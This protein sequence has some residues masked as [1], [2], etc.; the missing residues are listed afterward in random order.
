MTGYAAFGPVERERGPVLVDGPA[1]GSHVVAD[2]AVVIDEP[3]P[4]SVLGARV[5]ERLAVAREQWSITT[6][7]LFDPNS[8]R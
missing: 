8:W 5:R 2:A 4:A 1:P 6:F 7:F 3:A